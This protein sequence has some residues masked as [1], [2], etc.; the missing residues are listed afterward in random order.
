M[1]ILLTN[2]DGI[3]AP[4]LAALAEALSG[5]DEIF[6]SA[7]A[8]NRSG[9]GM[10]ITLGKPV[11]ALRRPDAPDGVRRTAVTGTPADAVKYALQAWLERPPDLVVSGINHGPNLGRNIR[12][13]GTVGA[14]FEAL[15]AGIPGVAVST[16]H[17]DP[18]YWEGA[19][20]YARKVVEKALELAGR[21][22]DF[23]LNLNVPG[24]PPE[25]IPGLICVPHGMGGYLERYV[26]HRLDADSFRVAGEWIETAPGKD[27][28]AAAFTGRHAVLTPLRFDMTHRELLAEMAGAWKGR[29]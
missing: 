28:D 18:P 13:S 23:V 26:P 9:V 2:D 15:A 25:D 22:R 21:R 4:G 29:L 17:F 3:G 8:E 19:K 24:L 10:G 27:S 11:V 14:V 16:D 1:S 5:V 6:I 20:H 12:C 7:P